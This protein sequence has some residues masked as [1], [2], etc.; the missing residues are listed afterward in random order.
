MTL[1]RFDPNRNQWEVLPPMNSDR[2]F[3]AAA[4]LG[5]RLYICGGA[6][7]DGYAL[8]S[9]ERFDPEL[10]QWEALALM[11]SAQRSSVRAAVGG[12]LY[13]CG[14]L[15]VECFDP[16]GNVWEAQPPMNLPRTR[17]RMQGNVPWQKPS[18]ARRTLFS[19]RSKGS[20]ARTIINRS[21]RRVLTPQ[22][23]GARSSTTVA[24]ASGS[25]NSF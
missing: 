1:E 8:S 13:M 9:A 6:D 5:G 24:T 11:G 17:L 18:P 20:L 4:A 23:G 2:Y 22:H 12:R 15:Q 25:P 3:S 10:N 19:E 7:A 21:D 14:G 16:A